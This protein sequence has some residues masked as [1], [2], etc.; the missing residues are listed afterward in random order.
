MSFTYG[1]KEIYR[2]TT[3][4]EYSGNP[5]NA[6]S[7][8]WP[9]LTEIDSGYGGTI[10]FEY[11]QTPSNTTDDI[12]TRQVV[13]EKTISSGIGSDETYTYAYTGSPQYRFSGWAQQYRGFGEVTETDATNNYV[14]HYFYTTGIEDGK[15]AEKLSGREYKTEWYKDDVGGDVKLKEINYDWDYY[16][17]DWDPD[18]PQGVLTRWDGSGDNSCDWRVENPRGVAVSSDHF[19]YVCGT[20]EIVKY[21][22]YGNYILTWGSY[23]SGDGQIKSP[24]GIAISPD[25]DYVYVV[26]CGNYRI[27]K[28]ESDGTYVAKWGGYGSYD[29]YFQS[30][31]GITVDSQGYVYVSDASLHRIQK[32]NSSGTFQIKWGSQ[33]SGDGY[34]SSPAGLAT[35]STV[36]GDYIYVADLG[37]SRVQKFTSSGTYVSKWGSNGTGDGQFNYLQDVAIDIDG[38]VYVNEPTYSKRIQKFTSSGTYITKWSCNVGISLDVS[39]SKT[40]YYPYINGGEP[41]T[42][43]ELACSWS[44]QLNQVDETAY[45]TTSG[46]QASRISYIY[47]DYDNVIAEYHDGDISTNADDSTVYRLY[48]PNTTTNIL[49]RV[50]RERTYT[51]IMG[52]DSGGANLKRETLYY[53]DSNNTS[54]STPPTVGM[55]TRIQQSKDDSNTIS[56]YFTYDA[57]GNRLTEQDPNGN[58]T[59]WTYDAT[60]HTY[61]LTKTYPRI[62]PGDPATAYS[63]SYTYDLGTNNKLTMTD[64]NGQTTTYYYDTFKRLIKVVKPG[65]TEQSPSIEYQY[66]SWGTINSQNIKTITKVDGS[67]SLW[68]ADYFDG[69][70]RVVQSHANGETGHTIIS[71][72]TTYNTRGLVDMQYVTQDIASTLS[73]YQAPGA[74][75]K[76]TSYAYDALGRVTLRL[77]LTAPL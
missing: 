36:N 62:N 55:L 40:L 51:T 42:I 77:T 1:N 26:D 14:I 24:V 69:L 49:S 17:A 29:G 72:T 21:D 38:N 65:D 27:Q 59:T 61:P 12:W 44:V 48:Y 39:C 31:W 50:A 16:I 58:T 74:G 56:A 75:W 41:S 22:E 7:I 25:G 54:L 8:S 19:V 15:E 23:G 67:T 5:G 52:S 34:L 20:S 60:Y 70:G 18:R 28:F 71:T 46:S 4:D 53:Y 37:N 76:Y 35:L 57:Y 11:T 68:Q 64:M 73:A 63:E 30:P 32:F 66:N 45:N 6:A 10:S 9:Y 3:E 13:T 33:G 43:E 47:D 2:H